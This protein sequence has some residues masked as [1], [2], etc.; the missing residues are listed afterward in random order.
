MNI[1]VTGGSGFIGSNL[2]DYLVNKGHAVTVVDDLSTGY[3]SNLSSVIDGISF[4]EEKIELFDFGKL[5]KI[6]VLVHLA[7]QPSVPISVAK[8]GSSSSSNMLGTIK[9]I[10]Y[11]RVNQIPLVYASSS[12]I[13][14]NLELGDDQNSRVDLLTPYAIDKYAM[15]LYAKT[16]YKLYQL[17][18][19]GLR[20]FNVYGQRQDPTSSYS[21]VISTFVDRLL[22]RESITINGGHQSRDFIYVND[23][24]DII[25]KSIVVLSNTALCEQINV[26]TGQSVTIEELANML[27]KKIG[28]DVIKEYQNLPLGDPER[29]KGT[30][31]K[32]VGLL[33]AD[34]SNMVPIDSGLSK[35]VNFMRGQA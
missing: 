24:V 32:M 28:V 1:L 11:C 21:G 9:V 13:Y 23:V 31:K 22:R 8:F 26:L 20:F 18:S 33:K 3:I 17:S 7:A 5:S 34:L 35:T 6:D 16:A 2:S 30:T 27:I 19:I 15:E 10:D 25:F 14:G 4:Y 29:S 12:A